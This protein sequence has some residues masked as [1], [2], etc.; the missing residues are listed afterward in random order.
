MNIV[1]RIKIARVGKAIICPIVSHELPGEIKVKAIT[2]KGMNKQ[3]NPRKIIPINVLS[4]L[5]NHRDT[6]YYR[7]YNR[8]SEVS[9][10]Q[11]QVEYKG[12]DVENEG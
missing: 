4:I 1:P 11:K 5:F 7:C 9:Y 8:Y 12:Y 10:S 6:F 2:T 3:A